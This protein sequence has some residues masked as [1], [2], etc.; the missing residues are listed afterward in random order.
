MI[1]VEEVTN[2]FLSHELKCDK[3]QVSDW[4]DKSPVGRDLKAGGHKIDEWDMYNFGDW[5]RI[6]GTAYEEGIND[7]TKIT[8]LLEEIIDLKQKNTELQRKNS[9]LLDKLDCLPF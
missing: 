6:N 3:K 1:T 2:F 4:M 8:R 7:Q 5:C 9:Q